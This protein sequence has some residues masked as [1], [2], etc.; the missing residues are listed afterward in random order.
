MKNFLQAIQLLDDEGDQGPTQEDLEA[1]EDD[2]DRQGTN[3]AW[4]LLYHAFACVEKLIEHQD[5]KSTIAMCTKLGLPK[6]L[7]LFA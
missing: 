2:P 6:H 5:K 4:T 7:L 3:K 1:G